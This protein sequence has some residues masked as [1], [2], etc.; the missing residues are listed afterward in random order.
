M[1]NL[2][3][4]LSTTVCGWA[5]TENKNLLKAGFFDISKVETYKEKALI[6]MNG[7]ENEEFDVVNVEENLSGFA[8]GRTS[9]QTILKLAKNKAVI[10]YILEDA[11]KKPFRFAGAMTMRKQLF[12]KA[13]IKGVKP[14]DYVKE[15]IE[16]MYDVTPWM[17]L[18]R[19]GNPDK[20]ME[21]LYDAIVVACFEPEL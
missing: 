6:L 14:K 11:W 19:D 2:G 13:R 16:K 3:L 20:K 15:Q 18:N 17:K 8:F 5:I 9:Q 12:G 10:C 4:D 7:L 1:K 21:D